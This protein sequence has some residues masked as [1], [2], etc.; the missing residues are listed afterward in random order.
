[1]D[2]QVVNTGY[3]TVIHEDGSLQTFLLKAGDEFCIE[4]KR[5]ATTYDVYNASKVTVD[6]IEQQLLADRI[7][8]TVL[9]QLQPKSAADEIKEKMINAL[10]DRGLD[11]PLN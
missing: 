3:V 5:D 9:S 6:D 10:S 1:M 8:R 2:K 7:A 11:T 4:A